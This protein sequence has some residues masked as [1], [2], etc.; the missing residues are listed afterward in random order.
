VLATNDL[1]DFSDSRLRLNKIIGFAANASIE[2]LNKSDAST[3]HTELTTQ[4]FDE[5]VKQKNGPVPYKDMLKD[6]NMDD[7]DVNYVKE[8]IESIKRASSTQPVQP[9]PLPPSDLMDLGASRVHLIPTIEQNANEIIYDNVLSNKSA[10]MRPQLNTEI[11]KLHK[12]GLSNETRQKFI[13]ALKPG[14]LIDLENSKVSR[15]SLHIESLRPVVKSIEKNTDIKTSVADISVPRD[16]RIRHKSLLS[17]ENSFSQIH[18]PA[19]LISNV[20]N[21]F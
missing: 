16:P 18:A 10:I 4:I 7:I 1:P 14:T 9:P 15:A 17:T 8:V 3:S 13:S 21:T 11:S 20:Q 5:I 2:K 6:I 19:P 12:I